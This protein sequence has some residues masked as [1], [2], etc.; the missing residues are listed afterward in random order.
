[1][2]APHKRNIERE[3][4]TRTGLRA[5]LASQV[6]AKQRAKADAA[7]ESVAAEA[8]MLQLVNAEL[9]ESRMRD[10][11]R[12]ADEQAILRDAWDKQKALKDLAAEVERA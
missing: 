10:L 3:E 7:C 5:T 12:K 1:M 11:L 4:Q 2:P 9:R 8:E 6:A